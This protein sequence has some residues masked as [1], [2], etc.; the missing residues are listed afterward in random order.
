[1]HSIQNCKFNCIA[2]TCASKGSNYLLDPSAPESDDNL[3]WWHDAAITK[4]G[5][6]SG[7]GANE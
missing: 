6:V 5:N 2:G 7:N 1:M 4:A 3:L